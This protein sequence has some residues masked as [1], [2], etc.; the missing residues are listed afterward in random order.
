M[1]T[2]PVSERLNTLAESLTVAVDVK[3][4]ERAA[5]GE[6]IVNFGVGQPD[7]PTPAFIR[8]AAA[9][10]VEEGATRYTP[11]GGTPPL[12]DAAA[13]YFREQGVPAT[14]ATTVI[15]CGAKHSLYNAMAAV[16]KPG[17][18]VLLPVPYW[19]SYPEQAKLVEAVPV[20]VTPGAGLKVTPAD[21]EQARTA[22][23]R[24][25]ILNS[26]G[27]P[28]GVLYSRDEVEALAAWC[29]AHEV[30]LLSDEIYDRLVFDGAKATSPASLGDEVA[31]NTLTVN[32]P[33][34]A[35]SM[36][37]WRIGF[38]TGP[39]PVVKAICKFQG[40]TTGNPAA[41]SQAATL[42]ALRGPR[43]EVETMR[44]AYERRRNLTV[45]GLEGIPGLELEVPQGAF[46]AFPRVEG[47]V[48]AAGGS[49][50]LAEKLVEAG[51]GVVPGAGFGADLHVRL[52]FA[53]AEERLQQGL[54]RFRAGLQSLV[55]V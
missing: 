27:N 6:D 33:S 52:S 16:L 43:D 11:P 30:I 20:E 50:P 28:S 19:V 36:T 45:Q 35:F 2:M 42:A 47:A 14:A 3:I 31:R 25:M 13:A 18:E 21:L 37:G 1:S 38:L 4:Q 5:R 7:F 54:E 34:K 46:Y 8:E 10:A 55:S 49:V 9:R 24:M 40:Q 51:V 48:R 39:E 12:R 29:L 44:A 26:P 32:G 53:V 15:S 22:R 23:T 17:D 41:V